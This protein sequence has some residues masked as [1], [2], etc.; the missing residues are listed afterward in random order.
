MGSHSLPVDSDPAN[1]DWRAIEDLLDEIAEVSKSQISTV[2]FYRFVV[3]RLVPAA[4]ASGAAIWT[5]S[6]SGALRLEYQ[7]NLAPARGL[8]AADVVAAHRPHVE[9]VMAS[10]QSRVVPPSS[11]D[12]KPGGKSVGNS[13]ANS[14]DGWLILHPLRSSA[15]ACGVLELVRRGQITA[16]QRDNLTRLMAAVVELVDDFHRNRE[17]GLLRRREQARRELER[18]VQRVHR[19]LDVNQTSYLL[20]NEGRAVVGCDRLSVL[21][22]RGGKSRTLATSGVD[23]VDRRAKVV[24]LLE[25]LVRRAV[26]SEE[27]LWYHDGAVDVPEQI[28]EPLQAY[29]DE[30][31]ART[32]AI[33]PL[34]APQRGDVDGP[35]RT[36]GA[37]VAEQFHGLPADGDLK[38]QL[39]AITAHS[40]T[41]L[42]NALTH[43]H[44]P[45]A[46]LGRQI[47]RVGWLA[48]ARQLPKTALV[49]GAIAAVAACLTLIPADFEIEARGELQP[50]TRREVFATDDGVVDELRVKHGQAVGADEPLVLLRK[51]ELDLEF[52]RM[53]GE[54]QTAEK[55]LSA[56]QAERLE[57]APG[58][59]DTR[60]RLHQLAADEAETKEQ[61][62]G[63]LAQREILEQQQADLVVR[64][65]LAGQALTWN[66]EELLAARPVERGQS[67][68]TVADLNGPWVVELHV[69]DKRAG[70]VLAARESQQ[71]ELNVSFALSADPGTVYQGRLVDT[72]L[73]TELDDN[74]E[75]TVRAI[76]AFDRAQVKALRPGATVQARIDCGRRPL[77]YVWFHELFEFVQSHWWW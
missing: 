53:A 46:W 16:T 8:P 68:L 37:L 56:I 42:N 3:D 43:S 60:R 49:L 77:G 48:E 58:G 75:V 33:V 9:A 24:R 28:E 30:T 55:K 52:R 34:H 31:H 25:R 22:C 12:A 2:E 57:N 39:T 23:V 70:H 10:D 6:T 13:A 59:A 40:A 61:L 72:A 19:S 17:L 29:V 63:L 47:A 44:L 65:P 4:A 11:G 5:A 36:I 67:L 1:P 27:P 64:S 50:Q 38:E 71:P 32:V 66:L 21:V 76:V 41:A 73:S 74:G 14:S 7:V 51:P 20:A 62:A 54:M 15:G 35:P 18:F 26:A 45:L 69:A